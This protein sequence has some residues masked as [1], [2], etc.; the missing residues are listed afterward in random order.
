MQ[1][2]LYLQDSWALGADERADGHVDVSGT[3]LATIKTFPIVG[4]W[5]QFA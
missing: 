2:R 5:T 1:I 4:Q 3:S